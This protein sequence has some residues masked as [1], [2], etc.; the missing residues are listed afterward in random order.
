VAFRLFGRF[1]RLKPY[2]ESYLTMLK[3]GYWSFGHTDIF[4]GREDGVNE[5]GLAVAMSGSVEYISLGI[6][7]P[8]ASRYI[9]DKCVSVKETS[10]F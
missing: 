7:F 6:G 4:V 3:K 9:L 8:I 10:R 1:Y 5:K 2:L